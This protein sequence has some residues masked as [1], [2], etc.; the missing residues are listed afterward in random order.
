MMP[1]IKELIERELKSIERD[2]DTSEKEVIKQK[3]KQECYNEFIG[4][5]RYILIKIEEEE[6]NE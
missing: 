6:N 1:D 5:L 3:I 4:V 2:R